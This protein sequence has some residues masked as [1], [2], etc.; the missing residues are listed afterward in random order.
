MTIQ[1]EISVDGGSNWFDADTAGSAPTVDFPSGAE[2]RLSVNND[3]AVDMVNVTVSDSALG[4]NNFSIGNLAIGATAVLD[5]GDIVQL[6][7]AQVCNSTTTFN[8]TA[9]ASG[10][11]ASDRT[12]FGPVTDDANLNCVALPSLTISKEIS[13]NS[14]ASWHAADTA[15]TAPIVDFPSGAQYRVTLNNT[16][17]VGLVNVTLSDIELGITNYAVGSLAA[18]SS[19]I[20]DSSDITQL[21]QVEVCNSATTFTNTASANGESLSGTS[22]GPVTDSANLKCIEAEVPMFGNSFE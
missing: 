14:G 9:S 8:N 20:L 4:I 13:L 7:Q 16:G 2:Y 11:S 18:G 3:G 6:G 10:E 5:S 12:V 17:S 1:K 15:G 19:V 22:I 21:N